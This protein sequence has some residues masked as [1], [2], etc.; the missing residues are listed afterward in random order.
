MK[1][2]TAALRSYACR[3]AAPSAVDGVQIR[4]AVFRASMDPAVETWILHVLLRFDRALINGEES[5]AERR[6]ELL[7]AIAVVETAA[8]AQHR[9]PSAVA[10]EKA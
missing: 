10:S 5:A 3:G 9:R 2:L 4:R 1:Q 6:H 7:D 8:K